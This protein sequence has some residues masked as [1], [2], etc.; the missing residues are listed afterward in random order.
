[1]TPP[2]FSQPNKPPQRRGP[3]VS[4]LLWIPL[5]LIGSTLIFVG[6][7]ALAMDR[8]SGEPIAV[9]R[10]M[11]TK[12]D[13]D[14]S[15]PAHE[16]TATAQGDE[17]AAAEGGDAGSSTLTDTLSV[18]PSSTLSAPLS[19]PVSIPVSITV[20][21]PVTDSRVQIQVPVNPLHTTTN[22]LLL[23]SDRRPNEPNWRT[24]VI[25][26]IALDMGKGEAGVISIPRDLFL[27]EIENHLP[28]KI[29]VVDYLGEQDDPGG[30]G[31]TLLAQILAERM[32]LPIHHYLRFEFE[33]FRQVVDALG[34]VEIQVDCPLYDFIDEEGI[35]INLGPGTHRLTG[36]QALSY[37]RTRR[38]GGDLERA[39]RQQRIALSVRDQ[40]L[41]ENLLPRLPAL[42][43]ALRDAVETDI[44]LVDAVRFTRFGLQL[45]E[46]QVHGMILS[47]P[48][49]MISG[50]RRGMFVFVPDWPTIIQ[51]SQTVFDRPPLV[52]T[53]TVGP[54]GDVQNCR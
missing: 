2:S 16:A 26:I 34:G 15:T 37:V 51:M 49:A 29:N 24:D 53:N 23:G 35:A 40:M 6:W 52:E 46:D 47:P 50:W 27:D 18:T 11:A 38:Q 42:Y 31:P 54:A 33:G 43:V 3:G 4:G 36:T 9:P 13:T 39:R 12:S 25:M 21:D 45:T 41:A 20:T 10:S 48:D 22:I 14:L 7:R 1:V 17:S 19:I 8:P 28:N 30:G 44:G 5:L 32:D